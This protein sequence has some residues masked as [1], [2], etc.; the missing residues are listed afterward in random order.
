MTDCKKSS[1]FEILGEPTKYAPEEKI[2]LSPTASGHS[3]EGNLSPQ[4]DLANCINQV[5]GI[6]I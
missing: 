4:L 1:S 2:V 5:G 6:K 3:I